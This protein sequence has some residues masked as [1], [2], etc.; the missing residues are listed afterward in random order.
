[1]E[2]NDATV[3]LDELPMSD[4]VIAVRRAVDGVDLA[5]ECLKNVAGVFSAIKQMS[6]EGDA[7][8]RLAGVGRYLCDD[9]SN[10]VA[11]E[12]DA[13]ASDYLTA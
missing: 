7:V 9:L 11:D 8:H 1:M 2:T 5:V 13:L 3:T 10:T 4:A 6:K 12:R